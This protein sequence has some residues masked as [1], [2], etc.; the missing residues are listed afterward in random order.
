MDVVYVLSNLF[1]LVMILGERVFVIGVK[2][3]AI[4]ISLRYIY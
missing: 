2:L 1:C 3:H 4:F